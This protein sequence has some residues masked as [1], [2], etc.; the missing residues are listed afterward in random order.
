MVIRVSTYECTGICIRYEFLCICIYSISLRTVA[1]S[2]YFSKSSAREDLFYFDFRI[3]ISKGFSFANLFPYFFS[4]YTSYYFHFIFLSYPVTNCVLFN[5]GKIKE[6]FKQ[7]EKILRSLRT[8]STHLK[9]YYWNFF[10]TFFYCFW[11]LFPGV[12]IVSIVNIERGQN[13]KEKN[14]L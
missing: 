6:N 2:C 8:V 14:Q 3:F 4:S 12:Y 1:S 11:F 9:I 5:G 10:F 13:K 7:N